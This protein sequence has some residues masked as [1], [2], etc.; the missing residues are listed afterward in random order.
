MQTAFY[1]LEATDRIIIM[2]KDL[3]CD[4][5]GA[6]LSEGK[7]CRDLYND[8]AFYTLPHPDHD[9][10][11]HQYAVDTYNAQH[12]QSNGK[13]V[14]LAAP[15]IGLYLFCEKGFTGKRV[16]N[17]HM[18]LGNEMKKFPM[19]PLSTQKATITVADVLAAAPGAKRDQAIKDWACAVWQTW[20]PH[21]QEVKTWLAEYK[22]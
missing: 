5:C 17:A 18:Q 14:A 9:L 6:L 11:I 1:F 20:K 13:P 3:F 12:A 22:A 21:A 4:L 8:L 10:F 7:T 2:R 15:L 19:F 16:Q